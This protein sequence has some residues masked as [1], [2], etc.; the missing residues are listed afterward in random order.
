MECVS[1]ADATRFVTCYHKLCL[2]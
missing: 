1:H 2:Y